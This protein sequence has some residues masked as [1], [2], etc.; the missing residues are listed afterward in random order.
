MTTLCLK[1]VIIPRNGE[2][3]IILWQARNLILTLSNDHSYADSPHAILG[4]VITR[5]YCASTVFFLSCPF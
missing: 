3:L 4:Q 2:A 1:N 5:Y